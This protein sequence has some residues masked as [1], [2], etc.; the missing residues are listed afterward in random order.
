[1]AISKH[2]NSKR[3]K[4]KFSWKPKREK[5]SRKVIDIAYVAFYVYECKAKTPQRENK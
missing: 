3:S 5:D 2:K 1:M 4:N